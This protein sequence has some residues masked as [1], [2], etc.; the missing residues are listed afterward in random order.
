MYSAC[1]LREAEHHR[2]ST[3]QSAYI[4]HEATGDHGLLW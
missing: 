2:G 4:P 1:L 3:M